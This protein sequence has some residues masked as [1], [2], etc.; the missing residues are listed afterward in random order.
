MY[1]RIV[2][3]VTDFCRRWR[4]VVLSCVSGAQLERRYETLTLLVV[5]GDI[6]NNYPT[7]FRVL[8]VSAAF[9]ACVG[10]WLLYKP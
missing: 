8:A 7:R 2:D 5:D 10:G 4:G 1:A 3:I 6:S 9:P